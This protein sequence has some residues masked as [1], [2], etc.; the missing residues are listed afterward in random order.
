MSRGRQRI[1]AIGA[2]MGVA[3]LAL[4][5]AAVVGADHSSTPERA[6]E[7]QASPAGAFERRVAESANESVIASVASDED[8]DAGASPRLSADADPRIV[9]AMRSNPASQADPGGKPLSEDTAVQAAR[10]IARPVQEAY[11]EGSKVPRLT[12]YPAAASQL[13]FATADSWMPGSSEDSLVAPTRC[14]WMITVDAPFQP[15]STP[16]NGMNIS[17]DGYT[18]LFDAASG[19]YLGVSAG[20]D[21]P[22][23]ITGKNVGAD[24]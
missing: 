16:E 20:V 5:S 8:C 19:E 23:L 17:F 9:D 3:T 18:V 1:V 4:G 13:T 11:D 14:V 7:R 22:N 12:N 2:A 21:T 15:R 10:Q 6:V 24:N